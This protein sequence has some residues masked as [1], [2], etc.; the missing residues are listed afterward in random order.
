VITN[1]GANTTTLSSN[2]TNTAAVGLTIA[3][4]GTLSLPN[5]NLT[6]AGANSYTGRRP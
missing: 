3:G 1:G 2:I 4:T 5:P 6:A